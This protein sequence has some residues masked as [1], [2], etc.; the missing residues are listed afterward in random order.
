MKVLLVAILSFMIIFPSHLW[1][2]ACQQPVQYTLEGQA[3]QCTGYLFSPDQESKMEIINQQYQ[4]LQE[5]LQV[6]QGMIDLYKQ[7]NDKLTDIAKAEEDKA[8]LWRISAENS[9]TKLIKKE[10]SSQY[11]DAAFF[12][13]GILTS[14]AVAY[15]IRHAGQN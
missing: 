12:I 5:Q 9:T 2:T 13:A 10:N 7:N 8:N 1:A 15:T 6:M 4:L 11:R 3:A 14:I